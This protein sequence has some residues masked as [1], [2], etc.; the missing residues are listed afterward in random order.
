MLLQLEYN[1]LVD[2]RSVRRHCGR[3]VTG[4]ERWRHAVAA[5]ARSGIECRPRA[6]AGE[7]SVRRRRGAQR[8]A[9]SSGALPR[10]REAGAPVPVSER[11]GVGHFRRLV[12]ASVSTPSARNELH[13]RIARSGPEDVPEMIEIVREAELRCLGQLQELHR[14]ARTERNAAGASEWARKVQLIA[15]HGEVME[16]DAKIKWLQD[17]RRFLE[18]ERQRAEIVWGPTR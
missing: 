5:K 4:S 10:R 15:M 1:H 9:G 13:G 18:K 2:G 16:W 3:H 17:V 11:I 6:R 12:M 7:P 8:A 14:R